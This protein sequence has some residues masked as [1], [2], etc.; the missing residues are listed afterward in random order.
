MLS[1]VIRYFTQHEFD[2]SSL[3]TFAVDTMY[4]KSIS[5]G[6][7]PQQHLKKEQF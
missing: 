7:E 6:R 4:D 5:Y 3:K 2:I 1:F